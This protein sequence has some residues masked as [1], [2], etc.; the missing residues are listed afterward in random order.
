MGNGC[1]CCSIK[2]F[3]D[4]TDN[5]KEKIIKEL[6]IEDQ[7]LEY[8]D[9]NIPYDPQNI[10]YQK[11]I[12]EWIQKLPCNKD[13]KD[14]QRRITLFKNFTKNEK[15]YISYKRLQISIVNYLELPNTIRDSTDANPIRLAGNAAMQKYIRNNKIDSV[16]EW[17]EFRIFLYYLKQ[18]FTYMKIFQIKNKPEEHRINLKEFIIALPQMNEFG[19]K[20]KE[21]EA[22]VR[23]NKIKLGSDY[24]TFGDFCSYIIQKSIDLEDDKDWVEN[25]ID[26]FE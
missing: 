6:E 8:D 20:L 5:E 14:L 12:D 22:E 9:Q 7:N 3:H 17:R 15:R 23:Y 2:E 1:L 25:E 21:T 18:Y 24:I 16:L 4:L 26:K 19:V 10:T 11:N 13:D